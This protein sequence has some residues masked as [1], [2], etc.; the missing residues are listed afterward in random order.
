M[1]KVLIGLSI[2]CGV[3]FASE[4]S[5]SKII[6]LSQKG[7]KIT[8]TLCTEE[9]LPSPVGTIEQ[10]M[11]SIK[12]S[13][14]CPS[15]SKTKLE[16]VAYYLS[17]GSMKHQSNQMVVP[18][19][20]K[21]PVCGMFVFK[22]PK[23]A[24]SITIDGK[25]YYFDGVKDMMKYYIF[26]GD[27]PYD[28]QSISEIMVSDYYTLEEIPAKEAYYVNDSDVFGPM[29]RELI[30]FKSEKSAKSFVEDHNGKG[31]VKF[32]DITDA[33]VMALDGLGVE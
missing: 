2:L 4:V 17:N 23:W 11:E 7:E 18:T 16:A 6:K 24:A 20:A 8:K 28:R 3:L 1:K 31:I 32:D 25:K 26:D 12:K 29:G 19:D 5:R 22:Y 27:F 10:V 13:K 14:A 33:M 15:L 9:K 21:C 30:P